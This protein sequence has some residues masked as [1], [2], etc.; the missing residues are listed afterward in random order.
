MTAE[1]NAM[2]LTIA[3][4]GEAMIELSFASDSTNQATVGFA[5]DTLNTAIYL[6]REATENLRVSFVSCIGIDTFSSQ[7][8]AFIEAEGVDTTDL[9]SDKNRIPGLY[10]IRTDADGERSFNYWRNESAARQLFQQ[11]GVIDFSILEQFN[12]LYL[13]GITLAIL[14]EHVRDAFFAWL[15][16][17]RSRTDT[18]VVFDSNY[19]PKLWKDKTTAQKCIEAMWR[20]TDIGLPSVDDE[21]QLF[22]DA[23]ES[24]VLRRFETYGINTAVLKRGSTG[25][26]S[27]MGHQNNGVFPEAEV[28]VDS[29]AAGDSFNGALL[30]SLFNGSSLDEAMLAGHSCACR[31]VSQHGA[32]IPR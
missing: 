9:K 21:M 4:I 11:D 1:S 17:Y 10:S 30:A 20:L 8:R 3:C 5:G 28:M 31:V 22:D 6:H 29:T 26:L 14:P 27:I 32:I 18:S 7:M 16:S 19:R 25:P 15:P 24:A 13:S 2:P 23:D 12:V